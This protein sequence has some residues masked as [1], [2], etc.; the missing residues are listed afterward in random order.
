LIDWNK[1][2][3]KG[4]KFMNINNDEM[5]RFL[6]EKFKM[7][8][9]EAIIKNGQID[10]TLL[11]EIIAYF[12]EVYKKKVDNEKL[13]MDALKNIDSDERAKLLLLVKENNSDLYHKI[14]RNIFNFEDIITLDK[15][16][17]KR[18]LEQF[19]IKIII[20]ASMAAS[21]KVNEYLQTLFRNIDFVKERQV[22]GRIPISEVMDIHDEIIKVINNGVLE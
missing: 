14:S 8:Y 10:K 16:R 15:A 9:Y 18:I 3:N 21:P 1:A 12:E 6:P 17:V 2:E 7:E 13:L 19:N 4:V 5:I 11:E 22:I 20:K